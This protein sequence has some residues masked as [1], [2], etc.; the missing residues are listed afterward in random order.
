M[1]DDNLTVLNVLGRDMMK[2]RYLRDRLESKFSDDDSKFYNER[3]L[4]IGKSL[5]VFGREVMLTDCDGKTREFYTAKYGIEEFEPE[6]PPVQTKKSYVVFKKDED[7]PLPPHNGWGTFEDSEGNCHGLELKAPKVDF[8]KF[9]EYDKKIL[10]F[11]AVMESN[12]R[13]NSTRIF[14]ISYY[15]FDDTISV[16][17]IPRRNMGFVAGEF[18]GKSKFY[19]PGQQKFSSERPIPYKSQDFYLGATVELR[20]FTFKIVSADLFTLKF[21]E[22]HREVVSEFEV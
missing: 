16:Y 4:C 15:L 9:I 21:L 7:M 1:G 22:D 17:E 12:I 19:H 20:S 2:A 8:K 3:D 18:F 6:S 5:N 11:G 14:V 10:R 13:E